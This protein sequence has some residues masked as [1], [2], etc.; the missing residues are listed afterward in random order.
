MPSSSSTHSESGD[1]LE[2]KAAVVSL[3][4]VLRLGTEFEG[5]MTEKN[6]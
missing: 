2:L 3:E 5:I 6:D 1:T 4:V